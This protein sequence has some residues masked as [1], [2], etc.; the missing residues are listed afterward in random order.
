MRARRPP[1]VGRLTDSL[2]ADITDARIR[3][4]MDDLDDWAEDK[5]RAVFRLAVELLYFELQVLI[6]ER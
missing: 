5:V 4:L 6:G 2:A 1:A 3:T